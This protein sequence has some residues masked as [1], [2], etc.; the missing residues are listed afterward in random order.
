MIC[1]GRGGRRRRAVARQG[2]QQCPAQIT[3][4]RFGAFYQGL[5]LRQIF[6][7]CRSAV[8]LLLHNKLSYL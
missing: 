3:P 8:L 7:P 2:G 1:A 4:K 6:C 5:V